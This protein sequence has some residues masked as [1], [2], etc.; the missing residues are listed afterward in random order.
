LSKF[1]GGESHRPGSKDELDEPA[2]VLAIHALVENGDGAAAQRKLRQYCEIT[3][4]ELD[5]EPR[6]GL[7]DLVESAPVK[8]PRLRVVGE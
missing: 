7:C 4:R 5:A 6:S 8:M 1:D 2:W 3:L